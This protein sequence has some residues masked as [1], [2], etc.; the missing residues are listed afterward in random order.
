MSRHLRPNRYS[1]CSS[2]ASQSRFGLARSQSPHG[3]W[4]GCVQANGHP[5]IPCFSRLGIWEESKCICTD[6]SGAGTLS[7]PKRPKVVFVGFVGPH[8]QVST[9]S[10][11][12]FL[13]LLASQGLPNHSKTYWHIPNGDTLPL[14]SRLLSNFPTKPNYLC[15]LIWMKILLN[16]NNGPVRFAWVSIRFEI[17]HEFWFSTASPLETSTSSPLST[18]IRGRSLGLGLF[19]TAEV[20]K[21]TSLSA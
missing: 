20:V 5:A 14:L 3:T 13:E 21:E 17:P 11:L 8:I 12:T 4:Y 15:S 18:I 10:N 19:L 7:R 2:R 1:R 16:W 6:A 9:I